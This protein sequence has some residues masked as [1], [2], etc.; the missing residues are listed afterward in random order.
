[1][2]R[3]LEGITEI[4]LVAHS[5]GNIVIRH[6]LADQTDAAKD[7]QPDERIRRIVML[8]PPNQGAELAVKFARFDP[9]RVV[10]TSLQQ[11]ATGWKELS[12]HLATPAGE[13]GILAGGRDN[14]KGLNPLLDGDDDLVVT[15]A[16]TR[17]A[18]A[19]DFRVLP[20]WHTT[21]MNDA[22][23][24]QYTLHFFRHGFFELESTRQRIE[25]EQENR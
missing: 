15:V 24:R 18:G 1:V 5:L 6:Y 2:I 13:F 11:L 17:L 3:N 10:G 7:K 20:V 14:Q 23:V 8:G 25:K 12:P 22:T 4:D 19:S 16:S 9:A 21:M